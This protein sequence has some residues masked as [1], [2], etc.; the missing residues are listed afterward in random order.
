MRADLAAQIRRAAAGHRIVVSVD[1]RSA[2]V[3][4]PIEGSDPDVTTDALVAAGLLLAPRRTGPFRPAA[5]T[6]V[7]SGV[8]LDRALREV[9]G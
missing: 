7:W 2:A 3:L 8:R 5:P 6:P 4:G 9:R 1:G